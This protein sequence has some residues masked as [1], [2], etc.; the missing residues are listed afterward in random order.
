M[1]SVY[2]DESRHNDTNSFM[3]VAGFWGT[4][5]QW[6]R[7][8][9]DWISAL[10]NRRSLQMKTLRLNSPRGAKRGRR[11]LAKL[12]AIPHKH[13]L[14]PV[15]AAVKTADYLDIVANTPHERR[16]PGYGVCLAAIMSSLSRTVPGHESVKI[17]CEIQKDYEVRA[18]RIFQQIR[19]TRPFSNPERPYF[20]GIEF[21]PKDSSVLTQPSDFLAYAIA[22]GYENRQSH[23]ALLCEPIIGPQGVLGLPL[24]RENIRRIMSNARRVLGPR[25]FQ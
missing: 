16:L 10:G 11:L 2:L 20:S 15:Y 18:C 17:V 6:D 1:I 22:E 9:P 5:E 3:V 19:V 4:K 13:G 8:T 23:K 7:F 14:T 24:Q 12:G 25:W 21:I